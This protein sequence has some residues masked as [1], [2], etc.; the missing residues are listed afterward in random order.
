MRDIEKKILDYFEGTLDERSKLELLQV[1]REDDQ[2]RELF[3]QLKII[4]NNSEPF[5]DT[6]LAKT[7]ESWDRIS[8]SLKSDFEQTLK[9]Q[10]IRPWM[11]FLKYAAVFIIG[12]G[13]TFA[14]VS[15]VRTF[16]AGKSAAENEIIV[17]K[18]QKSEVILSDGSRI[19]L[20]SETRLR[21]PARFELM[22]E[23]EVYLE[24]EAYFE[25]A[26]NESKPF[27]VST[28]NLRIRVLGTSFNVKCY[29]DDKLVETTLIE[30]KVCIQKAGHSNASCNQ[31]ILEPN[32]KAV[33]NKS[34]RTIIISDLKVKTDIDKKKESDLKTDLTRNT[35]SI[36]SWKEQILYFDNESLEEIVVK[37]ERWYGYS[38]TVKDPE[39]LVHRYKG[40]FEN[41]ETIYQ[42][43]DAI[44]LTTPI[45]Y[46][47]SNKIVTIEKLRK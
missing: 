28:G 26:K 3:F 1:I 37:L 7:G 44:R 27:N 35:E 43:L 34:D 9:K 24:G 47:V 36:T 2:I 10:K 40:K 32:Q 13:I 5:T 23:R 17:Q 8:H 39:L 31:V 21:Y 19:W 46:T 18:G 15:L 6:V 12:A 4:W 14:S 16:S 42:V 41:Y 22:N 20:N 38:I 30:G 29:P 33:F 11:N 45:H 25:V